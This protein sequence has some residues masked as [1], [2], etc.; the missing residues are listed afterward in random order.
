ME[1]YRFHLEK[2]RPGSKKRCPKCGQKACFVRY[3]DDLGQAAFP[4]YVGRCDH[5]QSC[6]YHYTPKDYFRNNPNVAETI[7]ND[8]KPFIASK[9]S[10]PKVT[11]PSSIDKTIM[12]QTLCHYDI[13]PLY[14][15]LAGTIGRDNTER[16]FRLYNVGTSKKW[17]GATVFWQVDATGKVRGGKIMGYDSK[18]GHRIKL[19]HPHV[20]WVHSELGLTEYHL[21]QCFFGEH[22]LPLYPDRTVVVVESEKTA[23]IAAHFMPDVIWIATGG[24]NGCFNERAIQALTDRDVILMPDLGATDEW[25]GKLPMLSKICRSVSVSDMLEQM[26]SDEQR[27][28]GLDIADFLLMDETP[29]MILQRMI[30]RNPAIQTLID[31]FG[32]VLVDEQ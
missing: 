26:A 15:Y 13:N 20:C 21:T 29:Q 19:P 16:L 23:I 7:T 27:S 30:D 1:N 3:V 31:K 5:E 12:E 28:Q 8:A 4:D 22:L 24:K 14:T 10:I 9:P 6:G 17:Q 25:R 2:Y 32:L 11:L 18:T